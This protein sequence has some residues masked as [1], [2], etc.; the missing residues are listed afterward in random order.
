MN[1]HRPHPAA[2]L[3][4]CLFAAQAGFLA[5]GPL[6]PAIARDFGVSSAVAG[7]LR[8]A[9]GVAGGLTALA[10]ALRPPWRG[11][12]ALLALG[13]A[14]LLVSSVAGAAAPSIAVLALA[15]LTTG[16]AI[17]LLLSAGVAAVAAWAPP[18]RQARVLAWAIVGQ[19]A[20][21]VVGMPA[22][23]VVAEHGWRWAFVAVPAVAAL[24]SLLALAAREPDAPAHASP[25]PALRALLRERDVAGWAWGELLAYSGWSG[26]LTFTGAL[27]IEAH[28]AS[29]RTTGLLLGAAALAYFPSTFLASRAVERHA[30]RALAGAGLALAVLSAAFGAIRPTLAASAALFAAIVAVAGTR[31]LAGSALGLQ[32]ADEHPMGVTSMRT[33]AA[34][35]G[36]LAGAGVGGLA[37]AL[38]GYTAF[39]ATT[40]VLFLLGA[41]PHRRSLRGLVRLASRRNRLRM[42]TRPKEVSA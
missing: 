13:S 42:T 29:A 2:V 16:I 38:G 10:L 30:R 21:W 23:G 6:L 19:P 20:A 41:L 22:L 40:G 3:F 36:N 31:T 32:L 37:L 33:A 4:L 18:E 24:A 12:R 14:L 1:S 5:L 15:Q 28:G 7:Q 9:S 8:V 11:P 27:M 35:F 26:I 25:P 17:A 39:G 34:Q